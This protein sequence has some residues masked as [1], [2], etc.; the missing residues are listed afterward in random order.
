MAG[1]CGAASRV[2][3][4]VDRVISPLRRA[5]RPSAAPARAPVGGS[6]AGRPD[7][8]RPESARHLD[9]TATLVTVNDQA[10]GDEP[11]GPIV[12][13]RYM[14]RPLRLDELGSVT[15][16]DVTEDGDVV[17]EQRG[18]TVAAHAE[19]WHR[20][21]RSGE[22]WARFE[23]TWRTFIPERGLALGA[24]DGERLVGIATLRR[25]VRPGTDQLEAL[26]VDRGH[27]RQGVAD[28]L[29]RRIEALAR[30]GGA[31]RLYVSATPSE[32]A[33]GFY[34]SRG[35]EP[36]A[37]PIP[38]LLELEPED[39]HMLLELGDASPSG[40]ENDGPTRSGTRP[41][42]RSRRA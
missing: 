17:L 41:A 36:T 30:D 3:P 8:P 22:T 35:F 40:A 18:Q 13:P 32:S 23:V 5:D 29:V 6:S 9:G 34:R 28:A 21:P 39:V 19:A 1:A 33:V 14:V 2:Q 15:A 4:D 38:E 25:A 16:I 10:S 26:F 42:A 31:R 24:F 37:E 7:G 12:S 20:P 11:R 27:R